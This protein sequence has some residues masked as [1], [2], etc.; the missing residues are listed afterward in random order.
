MHSIHDIVHILNRAINVPLSD[1]HGIAQTVLKG[2]EKIPALVKKDGTG[3]YVGID[4]QYGVRIYHKLNSLTTTV[5]AREGYGRSA[6]TQ[7]NTYSLSMIVFL[8]RKRVSMYP[9]ELLALLQ[10]QLPEAIK[11]EPYDH[12]RTWFNNIILNDLQ[13]WNQEYLSDTYRLL[14][15][16][17][18]FQINYT[19]EV[20]FKKGCFNNCLEQ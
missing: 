15:E 10:S 3:V 14:P 1:V 4:D 11:L 17:S 20:A 6:G 8:N 9:D 12:V 5:K 18:L 7:I 13:V 2:E 16:Y 19:V